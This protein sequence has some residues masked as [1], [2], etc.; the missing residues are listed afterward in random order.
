MSKRS[1]ASLWLALVVCLV[2]GSMAAAGDASLVGWWKLDETAGK[3]AADSSDYGNTGTLSGSLFGD[4]WTA[5]LDGG[6]LSFNWNGYVNCGKGASLAITGD[7]TVGAWVKPGAGSEAS[8][9]GV[10]GRLISAPYS[11]FSLV[12]HSSGVYRLWVANKDTAAVVGASS[13]KTYTA[14]EWHHVAGVRTGTTC[15]LYV[16]GVKAGSADV[17]VMAPCTDFVHIGMQY[18]NSPTDRL[19]I[20]L[21]DD[22]RMYN[23]GLSD[24]ELA[25]LVGVRALNPSPADGATD[26]LMP[27]LQWSAAGSPK[28]YD[29]Y[30][31]ASET[32]GAADFKFRQAAPPAICMLEPGAT[33]FWRVDA[34]DASGAVHTGD[35]WSF[36]AMPLTAHAPS[37]ADGAMWVPAALQASW[38]GGLGSVSYTVYGAPI[39]D[40]VVAGLDA[41]KLGVT[42]QAGFDATG[43]LDPATTYYWRVDATDD[44]GVVHPGEVWTFTTFDPAGGAVA[45]YWDNMSFQGDAKVVKIVPEVNFNWGDG[46]AQGTNSPDPNIPT[47]K[48]SCRWTAE[49][50]VP[51]TGKYVL[52]EASDDGARMW[53]NNVQVASGWVDRGTTEDRTASLDLVAGQRYQLVMEMYENGGGAT[54][55]L[56]WAGPG[57]AKQIIPQ[58]ALMPPKGAFSLSPAN[59]AIN[60]TETPVL[61]WKTGAGAILQTVYLSTNKDKVAA[62][63]ATVAVGSVPLP[64]TSLTLAAPFDRGTTIYW[65]VDVLAADG[66]T[67]P[68]L[69]SSFRI[70]DKNTDNWAAG[71]GASE[72][73]Y[74]ATFV[75][76]GTYDIGTFG[77]DQTYE[78]IVRCN[79][80]ETMTSLA[81]IGR[82]NFGDTKAGLKYEQ[83]NNTKHYGATIFGVMDYDY[84]VENA[85]GEYTH[86]AF[87]AN[88]AAKTT[89][90]YVNGVLKGSVPAFISLSGQV[91]IG[92]AIRANG[93]FVDDFDGTIFAVAIY[94]RALPADEIAKHADMYFNPIEITD[95]D[96]LIYYDFES[97]SGGTAIDQSG[98]SNHGQL[99][100]NPVWTTG[101]FGGCLSLDSARGDYVRTAA[102]LRIVSNHVT[103]S[104]WVKHDQTPAAWSGI[105]TH[106]GTSPGNIGL[107]HNGSEGP[108]GPELRYMWA[109][110]QYWS[111][112][113]GLVVPNGEW[114]FAA[115]AVS[116]TQA[117][118]YLNGVEKTATNVAEHIPTNFD[119]TVLI[120]RDT[121][122]ARLM[123]CLIDEVRFYNRTLTDVDIQRLLLAD[124]TAPGDV[125]QGVPNDGDWPAA[126]NP[127]LAID[128]N[129][130]TKFLHFKG[131]KQPAGIQVTPAIGATIVTGLTFTTANDDFGRDPIKFELSGSNDS[132]NGPWTLI[133]AGD[134][135]DFAQTDVWLRFTMN[136]TAISF[137][138]TVA[139]KHY[140]IMFPSVRPNTDG[141]MQ[142]AEIELLGGQ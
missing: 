29:I 49:L 112:S 125:V 32:L 13:T 106:R 135:V 117:K 9:M 76:N 131:G 16:D 79:P 123:T 97:G 7:F 71:I 77:G 75:Q 70:A 6:A 28:A 87:V 44:S 27:M 90:L 120:G 122:N 109:A 139:Y 83:W 105:L 48:F 20:G 96:L 65:K 102:P 85:P 93:T 119:T 57:I 133:A 126:E 54:A 128:D 91:G 19:W 81:L 134:I 40:A 53:L 84:G 130:G 22:F 99:M 43:L 60:V 100:G 94:G 52:Y 59:G 137:E 36:T 92:R 66:T 51:V 129:A 104:G 80:A 124:V 141:L 63:D 2:A 56:R 136:A 47:D 33:Y 67:I 31:G 115:L 37:P 73:N 3:T 113:S 12:R 86:L 4:E 17:P 39:K 78:F 26:V 114:Y 34:V 25:A 30:I 74:L 41:V 38:T 121:D 10:G 23:R 15:S 142:I 50:N 61:S 42:D 18:A 101:I 14:S 111:F 35:V 127:A 140:Q 46:A 132:I 1:F 95:P 68:G 118:L 24:A 108:Q 5:G 88:K 72:P 21:I 55:F 11:G 82:L 64:E 103:V 89:E 107:Q 98:H 110:D 58:G 8:Y 69:V 116:P 138:N 45:E 62:S